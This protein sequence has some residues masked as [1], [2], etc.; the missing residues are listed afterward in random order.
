MNEIIQGLEVNATNGKENF[1]YIS[2]NML[3]AM[4]ELFKREEQ[5]KENLIKWLEDNIKNCKK[6]QKYLYE[7]ENTKLVDKTYVN[8]EIGTYQ[9]VLD[10]FRGVIDE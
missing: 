1:C 2:E 7:K 4:K 3:N 9:G 6:Y 5:D 8:G 10:K